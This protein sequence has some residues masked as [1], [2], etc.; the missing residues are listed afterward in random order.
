MKQESG[1]VNINLQEELQVIE[2]AKKNPARFSPLYDKYYK[3][4]FIFILK[5]VSDLDLSSDLCS[6]VFLKAM[7]NL[8]K[9]EYRGFPFSSWLYRIAAN[10]V[11]MHF[12]KNNKVV[13][14]ELLERDVIHLM[15]EIETSSSS[16]KNQELLIEVLGEL[17]EDITQLID[18]RFFD[19][20]SFKEMG[21]VLGISHGKAKIR[22][23]RAIE[24]I[25]IIINEKMKSSK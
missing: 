11:N 24:K 23:Y 1:R 19:K 18:V 13:T 25:K 6:K 5:R 10:E 7:L 22:L 3:P 8:K 21:D 15:D 2:A 4:I 9:Y 14:V 20:L 17:P 16:I 12:R